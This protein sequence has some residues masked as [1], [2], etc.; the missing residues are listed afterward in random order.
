[1]RDHH[2]RVLHLLDLLRRIVFAGEMKEPETVGNLR[3]RG[4]ERVGGVD[5]PQASQPIARAGVGVHTKPRP[6]IGATIRV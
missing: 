2:M 6:P 1:M 5:L 3:V 4:D